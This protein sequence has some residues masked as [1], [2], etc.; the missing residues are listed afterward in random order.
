M[1]NALAT[2]WLMFTILGVGFCQQTN[3]PS[4]IIKT[5]EYGGQYYDCLI[6][7]T[8]DQKAKI[9]HSKGIAVVPFWSLSL[10]LQNFFGYDLIADHKQRLPFLVIENFE[11]GGQHYGGQY[12]DCIIERA[13]D[14]KA[15]IHYSGG[16][17]VV[18]FWCLS[19]ELQNYFGYD[20]IAES[21]RSIKL[22]AEKR[23]LDE[24]KQLAAKETAKNKALE[25]QYKEEAE[26]LL[27]EKKL[28]DQARRLEE[29][30]EVDRLRALPFA[31]L[32]AKAGTGDDLN[33]I[34]ALGSCYMDGKDVTKDFSEGVR[35]YRSAAERGHARA[36][37]SLGVRYLKGEGVPKDFTEG[38]K[39]IQKAVEQESPQ[40]KNILGVCYTLGNGVPHDDISAVQ[41]FREAA[42]QGYAPA[43]SN[44]GRSLVTGTGIPKD[45]IAGLKWLRLA[46]EQEN[47]EAL[48]FLGQCYYNGWGVPKDFTEAAKW[49]RKA[50]EYGEIRG[51]ALI[52]FCYYRGEGVPKDYVEAYKWFNIAAS[53]GDSS[54]SKVRD[55]LAGV[56][57]PSQI[58]EAQSRATQF[59]AR[60]AINSRG[61]SG[62]LTDSSP[63]PIGS[64]TGFYIANDYLIT[65]H[66]V[67]KNA[68]AVRVAYG[69]EMLKA[70]VVKIDAAN[71]LALVKA[72]RYVMAA[73][74]V[75]LVGQEE[76]L[77]ALPVVSSR[78]VHLG[79]SVITIGYPNPEV[80]GVE[81]KLTRGEISSLAGI[82]DDARYFQMSTA[83]QPGNS[84]GAL[85][86]ING[87]VIGVVTMRLN[88][89]KVLQSSGSLPQNVNYSLKSSFVNAFLDSVPELEGKL[90]NAHTEN[91][92]KLDDVIKEAQVATVR[93]IVY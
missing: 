33:A 50:A 8:N 3:L 12:H 40:G 29:N 77:A 52:G 7:R 63:T 74:T 55:E 13:K 88:D 10:E 72:V 62:A 60:K 76:S 81:P 34:C 26:R 42:E 89:L 24:K 49:Y 9:H 85:V 25:R 57:T 70:E 6:E 43:Q 17:T 32:K 19:L 15:M 59:V 86:N 54:A 71:D 23:E 82:K 46:I 21:Q 38:L 87:N 69:S 83:V 51:L 58:A 75:G 39:W 45:E 11:Y 44:L 66:H 53:N 37:A 84:G 28:K 78:D 16:V 31:E 90:R 80:Q 14:Q 36:Q 65:N 67:V 68:N 18:P 30:K 41:W 47:E 2:A 61:N 20:L 92:R 56:M 5:G 73:G 48:R 4:L 35:C 22:E 79:D 1:K 64:G 93:I 27:I 91:E